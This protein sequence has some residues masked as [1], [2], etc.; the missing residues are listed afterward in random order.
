MSNVLFYGGENKKM[1][2]ETKMEIN[3]AVIDACVFT[4]LALSHICME[5]NANIIVS[6]FCTL[7]AFIEA[8]LTQN[9]DM[10]FYDVL[11]SDEILIDLDSDIARI[12]RA[13]QDCKVFN[14]SII[15]EYM[16]TL[17]ADF[18]LSKGV[19]IGCVRA[20]INSVL[21]K[22]PSRVSAGYQALTE[23]NRKLNQQQ[24]SVLRGY[25]YN[26]HTKE[27]A[28][29]LDCNPRRIYALWQQVVKLFGASKHDQQQ[30]YRHIGRLI[31]P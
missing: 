4:Q 10:V 12:K 28:R 26:L 22:S 16:P 1:E 20:L 21:V 19:K 7:N 3:V 5:L 6:N 9:H 25:L 8:S 15:N 14:F 23:K 11:S 27:I 24:I 13:N 17:S 30:F 18:S 2:A 29:A 31:D